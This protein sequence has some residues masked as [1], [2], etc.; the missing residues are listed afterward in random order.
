MQ[1]T[2]RIRIKPHAELERLCKISNDLYNQ[3]LYHWKKRY[4]ENQEF[5]SFYELRDEVKQLTNLQGNRNYYL[6]K[7]HTSEYSVKLAHNAIKAFFQAIKKWQKTPE[8]F[9]AKPEFPRFHK[10]GG[11]TEL[12]IP[13]PHDCQIK[14]GSIKINK[15]CFIHIPRFEQWQ[16][17]F[18][19]AKMVR[20]IPGEKHMTIEVIYE[21]E[22][23]VADV[24]TNNVAAIDLGID[25]LCTVVTRQ[26]CTLFSGKALKAYNQFFNKQKAQ[27]QSILAK[28]T[29]GKRSSKR[30]RA[31]YDKRD[32]FIDT[33]M[34]TL[35]RRIVDMLVAEHVGLL[36]IGHN[37]GWKQ[38]AD[39][40][41]KGNQRFV[42]IPFFK[43]QSQLKYK[44][45]MVGIRC[46][47]QE[48]AYTSK[49]D[50]LA[51]ESI[52]KHDDYAGRRKKRG[53]FQSST[54]TLLNADQNGAMNILRKY[55]GDEMYMQLTADWKLTPPKTISISTNFK[56]Q[57]AD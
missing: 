34:H 6:M 38:E 53:L 52:A 36:V 48:E 3:S 43:M 18:Q 2:K 7:S 14:D 8:L 31:M 24:D 1:Q 30:I 33:Y 11:L 50:A 39:M 4:D 44:C 29:E 20:V 26:G 10:S 12:Y 47:E 23:V 55:L 54:G 15:D 57:K 25:N 51:M 17:R 56:D 35:T 21:K 27:L 28:Q 37:K 19:H 49:C 22:P 46:E 45:E 32:R 5:L 13:C 41:R 16:E 42:Q 9:K 40:G